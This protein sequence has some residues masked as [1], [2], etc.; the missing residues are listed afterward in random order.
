VGARFRLKPQELEDLLGQHFV[1]GVPATSM[2]Q[3]RTSKQPT[4]NSLMSQ[5]GC[6]MNYKLGTPLVESNAALQAE[7][8]GWGRTHLTN[9]T[10]PV[11][12][13]LC[14][15]PWLFLKFRLCV[16]PKLT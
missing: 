10:V 14:V 2:G 5:G 13:R 9:T 11:G 3:R 7:L 6:L 4:W 12:H 8:K 16:N 15:N 1:L